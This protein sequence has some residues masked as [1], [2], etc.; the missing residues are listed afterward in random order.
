MNDNIQK[1]LV[2]LKDIQGTRGSFILNNEGAVVAMEMPSVFDVAA[3]AELGPRIERL[4]E[5]FS[6][7]GDEMESCL[8]RFS[9][10]MLS[11]KRFPKGGALCVLSD[12]SVNLPA[13]RM[14]TNLAHKRLVAEVGAATPML[15]AKSPAAEAAAAPPAAA[16]NG[17]APPQDGSAPAVRAK[18]LMYRGH[19]VEE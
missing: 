9:D 15:V 1:T 6:A 16:S 2:A 5:S 8:V 4:A 3:F 11:I 19:L 18:P 7:L 13:L 14:A 12:G 17:S 10:H